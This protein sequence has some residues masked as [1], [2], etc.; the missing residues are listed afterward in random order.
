L[1]PET[2]KKGAESLARAVAT[3]SDARSDGAALGR[4]LAAEIRAREAA[5]EQ[6]NNAVVVNMELALL[7]LAASS[8]ELLAEVADSALQ[9][10]QDQRGG[11]HDA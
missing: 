1:A 10:L 6:A 5:A 9:V 4:A 2:I 3:R 8:N 7:Q 11:G